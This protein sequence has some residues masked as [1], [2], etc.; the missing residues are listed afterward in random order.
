VDAS[1]AFFRLMTSFTSDPAHAAEAAS[2]ESGTMAQQMDALLRS[3][4]LDGRERGAF[5]V[6]VDRAIQ[7]V[8]FV[9]VG[10]VHQRNR[11]S[12]SS[13]IQLAREVV[14]SLVAGLGG[15]LAPK[16]KKRQ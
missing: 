7:L 4:L 1:P 13:S 3:I 11:R 12:D 5:S 16:P 9:L 15:A 2:L 6:E 10:I 14:A 8:G